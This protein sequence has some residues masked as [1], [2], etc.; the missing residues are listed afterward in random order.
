MEDSIQ[1]ILFYA[2]IVALILDVIWILV[3]NK[4]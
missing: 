2:L 1:K 4:D 3:L